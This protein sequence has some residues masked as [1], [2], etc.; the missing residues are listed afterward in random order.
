MPASAGMIEPDRVAELV[1]YGMDE[2]IGAKIA[3]EAQFPGFCGIEAYA[4][5]VDE[6]HPIARVSSQIDT[7]PSVSRRRCL[8]ADDDIGLGLVF[9]LDKSHRRDLLPT[10]GCG[11]YRRLKAFRRNTRRRFDCPW[12]V[13][14]LA[15]HRVRLVKSRRRDRNSQS[16]RFASLAAPSN[17]GPTN[18]K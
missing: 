17:R 16:Q 6:S 9:D 10:V 14:A 1:G 18:R 11:A 3:V 13:Y 15:I 12:W 7:R 2:V 8:L 4:R 5:L